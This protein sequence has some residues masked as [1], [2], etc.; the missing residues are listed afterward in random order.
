MSSFDLLQAELRKYLSD[1]HVEIINKAY[2]VALRAHSKQL[3]YSGD[4]YIVHPI[5]V[6]L[7]LA[8]LHLDF[9]TIAAALLHDVVE[10]TRIQIDYINQEFGEVIANLVDGVTKLK[11]IEVVNRLELQAKNLRK[12]I[13]AMA[14]DV[15]VIIIK[16]AD[17]LHNIRT[18]YALPR[19]KQRKISRET[20]DIYVPIAR[21]LGM[22]NFKLELEELSFNYLYPMRS[23]L[24][25]KAIHDPHYDYGDIIQE[26]KDNIIKH[27]EAQKI[28]C[29]VDS[30]KRHVYSVYKKMKEKRIAFRD[31]MDVYSLQVKV[32]TKI[33]CYEVLGIVHGL[34]T[35]VLGKFKDYIAMPK[36]N[37][38]Q[39]LHTVL[40]GPQ[41]LPIEIQIRTN[42]MHLIAE[43]GVVAHWLDDDPRLSISVA[44]SRA[45]D[46]FKSLLEI[47]RMNKN[48]TE[49]LENIKMDLFPEEIYVFTPKG[50]I[51][52]L[53]AN[54]TVVDFAYA[55]HTDIGNHC[56]SAEIDRQISPLSTKLHNG[57]TIKI[58][59]TDEVNCNPYWLKFVVTGKARSSIKD[60]MKNR[61]SLQ[62]MKLGEM[63]L[64][65]NLKYFDISYEKFLQVSTNLL[66]KLQINTVKE[67]C[68]DIGLGQIKPFGIAKDADK[69]LSQDNSQKLLPS[70]QNLQQQLS[71]YGAANMVL[72]YANCCW[73]IPGDPIIGLL[74]KGQGLEVHTEH[75][76]IA[77]KDNSSEQRINLLW[78]DNDNEK[79]WFEINIK[80]EVFNKKGV[81][82][83][84]AAIISK[85]DSNIESI[86]T[87]IK[88]ES[89]SFIYLVLKVKNR[90]HLSKILRHFKQIRHVNKII[91]YKY[92][93]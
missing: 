70:S 32:P 53:P 42:D 11:K 21:R 73:P 56:L 59:T 61:K 41:G 14:T 65:Q 7:I 43:G 28:S 34:Y 75:C 60:F 87:S 13:L 4:P 54:A 12:M 30:R 16:I 72:K 86:S 82:A 1:E 33:K 40:F 25:Y 31:I 76:S 6:G 84:L 88:D 50:E 83:D 52:E 93:V 81:L 39:S 29:L 38:Y 22:H 55:V 85:L 64:L 79:E 57:Q 89:Y 24:L 26:I 90:K 27:C 92:I 20:L 45:K 3:R 36:A 19:Y 77:L 10:D 62:A 63:M 35:P 78:H 2:K 49:F 5:E 18:L 51:I 17:R 48:S 66:S 58:L 80:I 15:R 46:W 91:R 74:K 47:Q 44:Q 69:L 71:I 9:E 67:L 8:R 68:I 23:R 37:G